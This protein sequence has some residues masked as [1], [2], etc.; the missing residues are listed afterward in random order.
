MYMNYV[1]YCYVN[2]APVAKH[3][4][5]LV[6]PKIA[7]HWKTIA[8]HLQLDSTSIIAIA[9]KENDVALNC[10][11]AMLTEWLNKCTESTWEMLL[12]A[13]RQVE[14]LQHTCNEIEEELL[15]LDQ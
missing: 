9:Q 8:L 11:C 3:I 12:D 7:T 1:Q 13:V 4:Q 5:E 6:A 14:S 15:Q 10:C 2:T